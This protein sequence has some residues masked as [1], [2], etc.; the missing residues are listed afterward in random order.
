MSSASSRNA[1]SRE[2][3]A[4]GIAIALIV[5]ATVIVFTKS[6]P[7]SSSY[8]IHGVFSSAAQLHRGSEVRIGGQKIGKVTSIDRGPSSAT[9][10]VTMNIDQ[11]HPAIRTD[12]RLSVQPRLALEGNGYVRVQ[13]GTP[14]APLLP[15]GGTVPLGHTS[16]AVQL[17]QVLTMLD[18]P[19]RTAFNDVVKEFAGGLGDKPASRRTP[20]PGYVE[21]RGAVDEFDR[22]LATIATASKATRG[23][24]PG[25]LRR[26]TRGSSSV[27]GQLARNPAALAGIVSNYA[28]LS[29]TLASHDA[30]LAATLRGM[31]QT[32]AG[33]PSQLRAIGDA[34]PSVTRFA[35]ALTPALR[36]APPALRKL[37]QTTRQVRLIAQPSE[38]PDL[39]TK[40]RPL[41]TSLPVLERRLKSVLPQV[42]SIGQC[43]TNTIVPAL[44]LKIDD[45]HLSTGY[46]LWQEALHMASSLA[47][48][49][50]GFDANGGTLRLG[51]TESEQAVGINIGTG[52]LGQLSG[53]SPDGDV[54]MNPTWLG[55]NVYPADRPDQQCSSQKLPNLNAR[56]RPGRPAA[57]QNPRHVTPRTPTAAQLKKLLKQ[58]KDPELLLRQALKELDRNGR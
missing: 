27:A 33:A 53:L 49:A 34:L 26:A 6:N 11:R 41:T 8:E 38:L 1:R 19:T 48:A 57:F 32:F 36:A 54:G 9:S 45:G 55:Y 51:V 25:D 46:P 18:A 43:L 30:A 3:R 17:D 13:P 37:T 5:L 4:A 12:A 20:R 42:T 47:G 24:H 29:S 2:L 21:L 40:L 14:T 7:F 50:S 16:V 23:V 28:K 39:L 58:I 35:G 44:N 52:P 10:L 56:K 15:R 22:S 31:A